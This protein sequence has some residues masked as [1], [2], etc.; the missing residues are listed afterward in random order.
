MV[1]TVSVTQP[2]LEGLLERPVCGWVAQ[3]SHAQVAQLRAG[4]ILL[5]YQVLSNRRALVQVEMYLQRPRWQIWQRLT[6]Y[7]NWTQLLPNILK[8]EVRLQG[9]ERRLIQ[10]AGF[11]MPFRSPQVEIEL[12]VR[13]CEGRRVEFELASGSFAE[14]MATL[15]LSDCEAGTFVRYSVEALLLWSLPRMAIEHGIRCILPHNLKALRDRLG[16]ANPQL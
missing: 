7:A 10:A 4:E 11:E 16:V 9:I 1:A 14:F 15:S 6:D 3:R 5:D 12:T 13:E 2:R 8:S